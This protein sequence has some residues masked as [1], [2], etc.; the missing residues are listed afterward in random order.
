MTSL[1]NKKAVNSNKNIALQMADVVLHCPVPTRCK[2]SKQK[3]GS[4]KNEVK[5]NQITAV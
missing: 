3:N 2:N 5:K 1:Q 4:W